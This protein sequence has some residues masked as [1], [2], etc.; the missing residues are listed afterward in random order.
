MQ[1]DLNG[2]IT[3]VIFFDSI[4]L[5]RANVKVTFDP[6]VQH[7]AASFLDKADVVLGG[8]ILHR[9]G[10]WPSRAIVKKDHLARKICKDF[11]IVVPG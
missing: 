4:P 6:R 9:I 7:S 8:T 11:G 3:E 2:D 10:D 5:A 1:G